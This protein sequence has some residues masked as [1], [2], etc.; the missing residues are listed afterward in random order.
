[1]RDIIAQQRQEIDRLRAELEQD[2]HKRIR[3]LERENADLMIA[4]ESNERNTTAKA[5]KE[6]DVYHGM[7]KS[8]LQGC[9]LDT[10]RSVVML[11]KLLRDLAPEPA[12]YPKPQSA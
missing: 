8:F 1:M 2:T 5:I 11:A 9:Y 10:P 6:L 3:H 4:V 7:A 12:P